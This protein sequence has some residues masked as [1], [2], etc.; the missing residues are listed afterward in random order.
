[1]AYP[2]LSTYRLQLRGDSFTF[3]DAEK[4]IDYLA[5]EAAQ[6][7]DPEAITF[8]STPIAQPRDCRFRHVGS[9]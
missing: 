5:S 7:D 6:I 9:R 8:L 4:L 3:A 1:M 2:L